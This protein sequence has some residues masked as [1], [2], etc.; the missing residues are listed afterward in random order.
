MH[1]SVADSNCTY[2]K[3][4]TTGENAYIFQRVTH[5][6]LNITAAVLSLLSITLMVM[7][8]ICITMVLSKGVEFLLKPASF[9]FILSGLFVMITMVVFRQAVIW[10]MASNQNVKLEYEYSWSSACAA[11]AGGILVFGGICCLFLVLPPLPK[12]P[13]EYCM[14]KGSSS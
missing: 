12:K 13:W 10:L 11:A 5:K 1:G 7:G 2:F 6:D 4:F 3:F 8:S 14:K 9:F